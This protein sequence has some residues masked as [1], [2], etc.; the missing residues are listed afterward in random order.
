MK[1]TPI[2]QAGFSKEF[3]HSRGWHSSCSKPLAFCFFGGDEHLKR[4]VSS[5]N[6]R[7]WFPGTVFNGIFG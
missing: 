5:G 3:R 4:E 7:A 2:K 6:Y 1:H